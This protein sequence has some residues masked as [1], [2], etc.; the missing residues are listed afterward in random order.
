MEKVRRRRRTT[1]RVA[2]QAGQCF[3]PSSRDLDAGFL[4]A[5]GARRQGSESG[6]T[7]QKHYTLVVAVCTHVR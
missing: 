5:H 2:V 3:T 7:L 6:D 1:D 4:Y